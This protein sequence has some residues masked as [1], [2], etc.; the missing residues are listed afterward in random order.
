[1][2]T[3]TLVRYIHFQFYL[4][5]DMVCKVSA[6]INYQ[7]SLVTQVNIL[8]NENMTQ[9]FLDKF[10]VLILNLAFI[11]LWHVNFWSYSKRLF[12]VYE[13]LYANILAFVSK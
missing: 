1:M 8:L 6:L 13:Q 10:W 12:W 11:F 3:S 4:F 9:L 5:I 7:L 2:C